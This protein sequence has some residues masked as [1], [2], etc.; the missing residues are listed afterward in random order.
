MSPLVSDAPPPAVLDAAVFYRAL[1]DSHPEPTFTLTPS[2]VI[3]ECNHAFAQFVGRP[4]ATLVGES[5]TALVLPGHRPAAEQAW[6]LASMGR[7][8]SWQAEFAGADET[9]SIAYVTL[10][11]VVIDACIV[12]LQGIARDVTVYQVIEEQLQ[13]RVFTD[14]LTGLAS[15][16][17]LL[18]GAAR[19]FRRT[20]RPEGVAMLFLDLDDFKLV[21]DGLG[22]A[23]G[24]QVLAAVGDRL[25]RATRGA[26][27]PA[28]LGGDEFAVLLDALGT[29]EDAA[30]VVERVHA[31][32][33]EPLALDGRSV[34]TVA[35]VGIAHW[36]GIATPAEL[37]RNA[38]L[39]MY[40]AK[41][42]GKGRHA[43]YDVGMQAA[44]RERL[45][46]AS[47]LRAALRGDPDGGT[48]HAAYQPIVD[49][50]SGAA[51]KV[52][53]LARWTHPTRGTVSPGVFIP[54]AEET[55]L[56]EELGTF[57]LRAGCRQLRA[58]ADAAR[59]TGTAPIGVT[60]NISGRQIERGTL[61]ATVRDVLAETGA[62]PATLTLEITESVAMRDPA[63]VLDTLN[64]L[65]ALGVQLAIDDFGTGYSSLSYL[66][67]F[68]LAALKIDKSFVDGIALDGAAGAQAA[69]LVRAV[70]QM[71][72]ALGLQTVAEGVETSAQH[73]ML[74]ALGCDLAQGYLFGRPGAAAAVVAPG[75]R[76]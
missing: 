74:Q 29:P 45:E 65:T 61:V 7:A 37:L 67:R 60:V 24:D 14:P 10:V 35:S 70:V 20:E 56:I 5:L 48:L 16:T 53:A 22:H 25:R 40:R 66:Q 36:D 23:V 2:G 64:A 68:P 71:A 49:A 11:P 18:E 63:R 32:L 55:G 4:G 21:N 15:R 38:D 62:D 34:M 59:E 42:L 3:R 51:V 30:V 12:G 33:R 13:A 19:A 76:A 41:A 8:Q 58:W 43:V 9:V 6:A 44:A 39:A 47:D 46:V 27:L 75:A 69:G 1:L 54:V 52:E 31:A 73:A 50:A 26:D 57:M 28:R 17:Q 72:A